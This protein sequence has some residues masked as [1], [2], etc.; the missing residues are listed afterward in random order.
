VGAAVGQCHLVPANPGYWVASSVAKQPSARPL[1]L[2]L[3][4]LLTAAMLSGSAV[5]AKGSRLWMAAG[6]VSFRA[7]GL[8]GARCA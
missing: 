3:P 4:T 8:V 2:P 1:A 6:R 5:Q 7:A